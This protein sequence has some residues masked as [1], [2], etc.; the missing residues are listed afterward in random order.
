MTNYAFRIEPLRSDHD[1]G[2]FRCGQEALDRYF[3]TQA[4]QDIKRR[5]ANCY[6]AIDEVN[7]AVAGFYTLSAAGIPLGDLP[8]TEVKRLPRY[9]SVPAIR[10]GRL[11]VDLRYQGRGLGTV[12]LV[13][14]V[15]QSLRGEAAAFALMVDAKDDQAVAFYKRHGFISIT[16]QGRTLYLPL[17]MA[18][19]V[20][21]G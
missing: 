8:E 7:G 19:Q 6:V 20:M 12:M 16:S 3:Q 15:D 11:A 17:A 4:T 18:K 14:A 9:G 2:P 10:I 1:G 5:I 13:K 21:G